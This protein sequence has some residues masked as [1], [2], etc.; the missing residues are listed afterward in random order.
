MIIV[1]FT[2]WKYWSLYMQHKQY[3]QRICITNM[4]E[5]Q[6]LRNRRTQSV[7]NFKQGKI[8]LQT[9]GAIIS[10]ITEREIELGVVY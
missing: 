5:I 3:I 2:D 4:Q 1:W 7:N 6:Q 8:D 9:L 10:Q